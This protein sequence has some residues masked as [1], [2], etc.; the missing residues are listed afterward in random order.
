MFCTDDTQITNKALFGK[1]MQYT[2][3]KLTNQMQCRS[4]A[5]W[6]ASNCCVAMQKLE[7]VNLSVRETGF[8]V[9]VNYPFLGVLRDGIVSCG[10]HAQKTLGIK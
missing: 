7:F 2:K 9:R 8:H 10:C 3:R 4:A 5:K 1:I 6:S